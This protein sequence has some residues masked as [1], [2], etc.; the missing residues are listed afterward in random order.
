MVIRLIIGLVLA[1]I[2]G[3]FLII[4]IQN[5][6]KTKDDVDYWKSQIPLE[7][8]YYKERGCTYNEDR[9]SFTCPLGVP[10]WPIPRD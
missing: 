9:D 3:Y 5:A 4:S 1:V 2:F 7:H 6:M 8:A 10:N